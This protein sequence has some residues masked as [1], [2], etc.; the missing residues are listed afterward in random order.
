MTKFSYYEGNIY[1]SDCVGHLTLRNFID[2]HL[3]PTEETKQIIEKIGVVSKKGDKKAKAK[4]KERLFAFTPSVIVPIG[5]PRKYTSIQ[6][7]T[8]LMQ[9]DFDNIPDKNIA[10][11][12]KQHLFNMYEEIICIYISPSGLGVKALM[13]ITIAEDVE[14]Y[15]A[16]HKSVAKEM[17]Q[18]GYFD[19]ATKNAILPLFLSMDKKL[20]YRDNYK[21]WVKED[22]SKDKVSKHFDVPSVSVRAN[23]N[24]YNMQKVIRITTK[25]VNDIVSDGHPQLRSAALILGSRVGAGY[26][27]K[28][29]A[30]Q[31]I[32]NLIYS[33]AYLQKGIKG[34][35]ETALWALNEGIRNP[36]YF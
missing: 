10:E 26:M 27:D 6:E 16:I 23:D 24:N 12:L 25:R 35:V 1:K 18:Y 7:F 13:S 28:I 19:M 3:N 11:N 9:L 2:V 31:L 20:L 30:E 17:E 22:W 5:M 21:T 15:K 8:G 34:Y 32:T 33:N 29:S 36:K 14:H 4:L